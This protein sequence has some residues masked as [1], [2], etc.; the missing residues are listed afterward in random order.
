MN[1]NLP[2]GG[3]YYTGHMQKRCE[4]SYEE[5]ISLENLC[6]AWCEFIRGRRN[7]EDVQVFSA[8]LGD[9]LSVLHD[10]LASGLY[11]HGPYRHFSL[12]DPKPRIIHKATVR[13]HLLH[14]AIHRKLYPFFSSRFIADSLSCQTGKG[15]HRALDR[16]RSASRK[17][18]RNHS[19]TCWVL[20]CDIRKFF[21]SI[22]HQVL[23]RILGEQIEDRQ[24]RALL[25][26]IIR[27]FE[28][29]PGKGLPLGNLTSQLFSNVYLHEFD[30][31]LKKRLKQK[32]Y[33]RYADDFA[34]FSE[35]KN[36]LMQLL[37]Q[38]RAF[39][40]CQLRL[41]VHPDKIFLKTFASG[42]D[43]LGW[44]H[45]PHH[46]ILRTKTKKR[47]LKRTMQ[48]R[49][50]ASFQ[51]YLGLLQYGDTFTLRTQLL[52]NQWFWNIDE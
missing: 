32:F 47:V 40:T 11:R 3:G 15:V 1:V 42:M 34:F 37:P 48:N 21:A 12:N 36:L 26:C 39:L 14:H 45:F 31:F 8:N 16:F 19:R 33:I 28:A 30:C 51:S 44:V 5:V 23:I 20:K 49:S 38:V 22:D 7:K 13:D 43:F 6:E 25:V 4:V 50:D 24:L 46:R 27:S 2:S 18:G 10:D 17:V 9:A 52:N 41:V 29:S 35:N